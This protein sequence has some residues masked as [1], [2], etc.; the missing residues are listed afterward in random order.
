M[1][2]FLASC[3]TNRLRYTVDLMLREMLGLK[4]EMTTSA[5]QFRLYDGPKIAYS[6][7]LF[8]DALNIESSGLL[9]EA[10]IRQLGL[11]TTWF[12][13]VPVLFQ[14]DSPGYPLPYDPFSATFFMV[15]RYEEYLPYMKDNYGRFPVTASVAWEGRFLE[16]PVVHLWT[17][18]VGKLLEQQ[19]PGIQIRRREYRF[20]PTIDVDHAFCYRC[21]PLL[22]TLGG[23]GRSFMYFELTAILHRLQ[24]LTRLRKDPYD[25]YDYISEIH[26]KYGISP[27]YFMLFA[28]YGGD[29]NNV[30][31]GSKVFQR[32]IRK[33]DIVQ[34]VGIHP[35]L[36]S[37]KH[38]LKLQ[39]EFDGLSD[40]VD[41]TIV[42]SRQHFLKISIPRTYRALNQLGIKDDYSMGYSSQPGFR[43]G[44]AIPY[45]FFDISR[46]LITTL[47]IHPVI[48]M[49]V[50][51]KDK[52]RLNPEKGLAKIANLIRTVKSVDGDFVSLWHNESLTDKGRWLGWRRVFEEM[53]HL[54]ST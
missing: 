24:V 17:G 38:Y 8:P 33:L 18:M 43:A 40:V 5:D 1:L 44:I 22:R 48:M 16:I 39:A 45:P 10:G 54:A 53:V 7:A 36:S 14:S 35:S 46:N 34:G 6:D 2:L 49:D 12:D 3:I 20:V 23:I 31:T 51:L 52:L 11:K 19:F 37:N 21:R 47:M 32:L 50:T 41:R 30:S 28:D 26:E 25:T 29:D 13:S 9:F 4:V 42:H 15:S 27:L